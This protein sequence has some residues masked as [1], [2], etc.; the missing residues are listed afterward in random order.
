MIRRWNHVLVAIRKG[1]D[2]PGAV[3]LGPTSPGHGRLRVKSAPL[4]LL[5]CPPRR[6]RRCAS[7]RINAA[8]RG[9][10]GV[11]ARHLPTANFSDVVRR[12]RRAGEEITGSGAAAG[13]PPGSSSVRRLNKAPPGEGRSLPAR[14]PLSPAVAAALGGLASSCQR[15][16]TRSARGPRSSSSQ[17]TAFDWFM[18]DSEII[19]TEGCLFLTP[20]FS[21]VRWGLAVAGFG[22]A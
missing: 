2:M 1:G 14:T 8:G 5:T 15:D 6:G 12:N 18:E 10:G 17:E 9:G 4:V 11:Q 19:I 13:A 3:E 22:S 7:P 16:S 20:G 21:V